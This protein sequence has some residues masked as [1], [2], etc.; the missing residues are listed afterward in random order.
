MRTVRSS[1]G[2]VSEGWPTTGWYCDIFPDKMKCQ[3]CFQTEDD[4]IHYS[5]WSHFKAWLV[6]FNL[7]PDSII[8]IHAN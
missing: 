3:L 8:S 6:L 4:N 5:F 7:R 2:H 1:Y